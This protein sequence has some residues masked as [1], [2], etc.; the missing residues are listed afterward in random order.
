MWLEDSHREKAPSIKTPALAKYMNMEIWGVGT[1]N[2]LFIEVLKLKQS[3][4]KNKVAAKPRSLRK[5]HFVFPILV[6]LTLAYDRAACLEMLH[7]QCYYFQPK[8]STPV[9]RKFFV[10][11]KIYFKLLWLSHKKMPISQTEGCFKIP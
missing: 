3:F 10:F 4:L 8:N 5:V 9:F 7:F 6:I 1:L 11:Q 2:Q